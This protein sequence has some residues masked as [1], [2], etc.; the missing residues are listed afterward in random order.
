MDKVGQVS[1]IIPYLLTAY[2]ISLDRVGQESGGE[3]GIRTHGTLARSLV[4]KTSPLNHSGTSPDAKFSRVVNYSYSAY[5][6]DG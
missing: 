6:Q 2:N 3:G 5:L 4:F 1:H